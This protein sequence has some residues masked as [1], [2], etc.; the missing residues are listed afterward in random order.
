MGL[1]LISE[2][3]GHFQLLDPA[4]PPWSEVATLIEEVLA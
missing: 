1:R 2:D 3:T 4:R